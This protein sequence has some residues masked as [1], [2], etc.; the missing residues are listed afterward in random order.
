VGGKA[1]AV[2]YRLLLC[3]CVLIAAYCLAHAAGLFAPPAPA[4]IPLAKLPN[5]RP[6][7]APLTGAVNVNTAPLEELCTLPGIGP[8]LAGLIIE[9]RALSPFYYAEDLKSVRGIGDRRLEQ[10]RPYIRLVD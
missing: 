5:S 10:I 4:P 9:A 3:A 6:T 1:G 7:V 2:L 8:H